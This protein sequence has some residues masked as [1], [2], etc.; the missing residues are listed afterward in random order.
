M[1]LAKFTDYALRM[2]LYLG[3][4]PDRRVSISEI[5][6]AHNISRGNMMKVANQ[7]VAAGVL[8]S[9]R[10]RA[11]GLE[12]ARPASDIG[13]GEL[14]RHMEG[15]HQMVDC[16]NCI[17]IGKCGLLGS[18]QQAKNAFYDSLNKLSLADALTANS[19]T[20]GILQLAR[21]GTVSRQ[22]D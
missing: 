14:T 19:A 7:L 4:H 20:V 12:L 22:K 18:L 21:P 16:A 2:C 3:A 8:Q 5:A 15:D 10:G 13:I 11:G 17:L 6:T 1:H 9:T